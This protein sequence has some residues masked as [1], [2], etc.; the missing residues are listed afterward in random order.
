MID[1]W[2]GWF[3]WFWLVCVSQFATGFQLIQNLLWVWFSWDRTDLDWIKF[4]CIWPV[5][6]L[7]GLVWLFWSSLD[8]LDS[9]LEINAIPLA[10]QILQPH[11]PKEHHHGYILNTKY[12]R[13]GLSLGWGE[14]T[15][16]LGTCPCRLFGPRI[17]AKRKLEPALSQS[18]WIVLLLSVQSCP[19]DFHDADHDFYLNRVGHSQPRWLKAKPRA[20]HKLGIR[21]SGDFHLGQSVGHIYI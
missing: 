7:F 3:L 1:L 10:A 11:L 8:C 20:F 15:E 17:A 13:A 2:V 6:I 21:C 5:L 4:G 16:Y 9:H 14:H 19:G 12:L 18:T